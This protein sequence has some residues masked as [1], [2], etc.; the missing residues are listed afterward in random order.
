[1]TFCPTP[2]LHF[3]IIA[4]FILDVLIGD[5]QWRYH[6]VRLI[7]K[8]IEGFEHVL[9]RLPLPE[10]SAGMLLTTVIAGSV[11][12]SAFVIMSITGQWCCMFETIAGAVI[13][14]FSISTKSLADEAKKVMHFLE[15]NDLINARKALSQI[16][17]RDT[18]HL[19]DEQIVRA[20]VET[21]AESTVDGILSPLFFAFMG[22]P[23]AAMAYR[24][25]NTMDSMLGHKDDK[26]LRFGWA[27]ARL[28]D[29]ANYL[30][31]RIS[32]LLIPVAAFFC[33]YSPVR[34]IKIA[35][36]DGRKHESPNSGISEAAMAGALGVQL[37]GPSSYQ[38]EIIA[39]PFIGDA[40]NQLTLST[41]NGAIKIMFVTAILFLAGGIGIVMALQRLLLAS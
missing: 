26:Y 28:D 12:L 23:P 10:R 9:R 7:G 6:P 30:P 39:K 22:G 15:N 2:H 20:C 8:F 25:V 11:W 29:I 40:H 3:Q 34:S 24:A 33:G 4:A 37:G 16:V 5:P 1:V 32:A 18:A 21:V 19:N 31:A 41:I 38:G 35:I 27:S 13:I 17:G 14:Y 36:R